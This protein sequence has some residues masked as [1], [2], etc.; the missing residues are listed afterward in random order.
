EIAE[1]VQF[2][3]CERSEAISFEIVK[4]VLNPS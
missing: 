4:S 2:R 3:H 1:K